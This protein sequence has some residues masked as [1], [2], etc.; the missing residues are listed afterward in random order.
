MTRDEMLER[1]S[2][3]RAR[4]DAGANV[5][6]ACEQEGLNYHQYHYAK[7]LWRS[8]VVRK[9]EVSKP[10]RRK[11]APYR[12]AVAPASQRTILIVTHDLRATLEALS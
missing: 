8:G 4:V 7:K 9:I 11:G 1:A 6:S 2:R 12:K 3:V 10:G 5:R